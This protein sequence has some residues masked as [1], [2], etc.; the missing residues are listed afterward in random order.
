MYRKL[1]LLLFLGLSSGA[2][3]AQSKKKV[4][5]LGQ[6]LEQTKKKW[7]A[8]YYNQAEEPPLPMKSWVPEY[9]IR[10]KYAYNGIQLSIP[11]LEALLGEK[12][13]L[14]GPHE[15]NIMDWDNDDFGHYNP[16]FLKKLKQYL[17]KLSK[18]KNF[19][20][21]YQPF[22]EANLQQLARSYFRAEQY[23]KQQPELIKAGQ[24]LEAE[25]RQEFFRDYSDQEETA[26]YIWYEANTCAN[27]WLRRHTDGS[28][29]EFSDLLELLLSTFDASFLKNN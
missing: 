19:V 11:F 9:G 17:K 24:Q 16:K 22:Y 1:F 2:I 21:S 5:Q 27:F 10:G 25:E 20:S 13:F 6:Q 12:L 23:L 7:V 29:D 3:M 28:A 8:P 26:G 14:S 18:Q 15:G 4:K